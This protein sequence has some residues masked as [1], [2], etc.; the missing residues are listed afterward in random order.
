[1]AKL[2]KREDNYS[3]WYNELVAKADLA[4]NSDVRGCMII[5]PYGYS[6]WEKMQAAL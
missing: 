3:Q 4:E 6:I 1:M 2:T 5:K